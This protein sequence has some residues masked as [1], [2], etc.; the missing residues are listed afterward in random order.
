MLTK[1]T[2]KN[3][4][5]TLLLGVLIAPLAFVS[6]EGQRKGPPP[7]GP[8]DAQIEACSTLAEGDTCSFSSTEGEATE[9]TCKGAPRGDGPLACVTAR[10]AGGPP[11]DRPKGP[12]DFRIK[13]FIR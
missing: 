3:I 1:K 2:N 6:A 11:G 4:L 10:G 8:S 7:G 5:A 9:G 12:Q 13:D